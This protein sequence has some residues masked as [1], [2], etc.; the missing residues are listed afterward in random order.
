MALSRAIADLTRKAAPRRPVVDEKPGCAYG[1]VTRKSVEDLGKDFD[2]L[3]DKINGLIFGVIIT[4]LLQA[5]KT[6]G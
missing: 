4:V 1:L 6:L 5:W 2:R 3:E